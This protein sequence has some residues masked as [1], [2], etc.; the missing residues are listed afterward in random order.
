MKI[1]RCAWL[2]GL[3]LVLASTAFAQSVG[4]NMEKEREIWQQLEQ[5][6]PQAVEPFKAATVAYDKEEMAEAVRL[7]EEVLK[8]VPEFDPVLRRLGVALTF[9][10]RGKE[11]LA[12]LEQALKIK[13]TP[14]NMSAMAYALAYPGDQLTRNNADRERALVLARE[15][16]RTGP[17]DDPYYALLLGRI[18][19]EMDRVEDFREATRT[20][21]ANHPNLMLTHYFQA[22]IAATDEDWETAEKEIK[23]A[24]SMGLPPEVVK[25]FLDTGV[26]TQA[27]A[28]RYGYY[29]L[30]LVAAWAV[31]LLLLFI[32]GK[33]LSNITL[34]AV[35][36]GDP[37]EP[38]ESSQMSLRKVY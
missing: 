18:A 17:K 30:Y 9:I 16:Y 22:I 36:T 6:A 37:N 15:S 26:H 4:R 1:M 11:G 2:C 35:E 10:G 5:I 27:L 29:S 14:E 13:R 21:V 24:E 8:Q 33:V 38:A 34:R 19:L 32:L 3:V 20:L 25:S 12:Y 31:G 7:Y 23:L 28:W